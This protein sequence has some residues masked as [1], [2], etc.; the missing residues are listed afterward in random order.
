MK[1][2]NIIRDVD[3]NE[4]QKKQIRQTHATN[5]NYIRAIAPKEYRQRPS[6]LSDIKDN[7]MLSWI[8]QIA[9]RYKYDNGWDH[10]PIDPTYNPFDNNFDEFIP[11]ADKF[12]EVYNKEHDMALRAQI[13]RNETRR[14]RLADGDRI[15][16]A[17]AAGLLDPLVW[18]PI[19]LA[20]GVG[21]VKGATRAGLATGALVGAT[22]PIRLSLDPTA[23]IDE[24]ATVVGMGLI[25]G[26]LIGGM[27]GKLSGPVARKALNN[28]T[29]KQN[30]DAYNR[31]FHK[32]KG[33]VDFESIN[34]SL[35][36]IDYRKNAP[37]IVIR[38]INTVNPKVKNSQIIQQQTIEQTD[39]PDGYQA[40]TRRKL[41]KYNPKTDELEVD[42][43]RAKK[44]YMD[45]R[46]LQPPIRGAKP[47]NPNLIPN[48]DEYV[49]FIIRKEIMK[50]KVLPKKRKDESIATYENRINEEVIKD[51]AQESDVSFE[52]KTNRFF[53]AVEGITNVG[54]L[55]IFTRRNIGSI[56]KEIT[57]IVQRAALA[58][59]DFGTVTKAVDQGIA[60]NP[61]II[62]KLS[63]THNAKLIATL[64][65][66]DADFNKIVGIDENS[67]II[68]QK[69]ARG[70]LALDSLVSKATQQLEDAST[71]GQDSIKISKKQYTEDLG[72]YLINP[73]LVDNI[74]ITSVRNT[75]KNSLKTLRNYFKYYNKEIERLDMYQGQGSLNNFSLAKAGNAELARKLLEQHKKKPF[76]RLESKKRLQQI[77]QKLEN[78]AKRRQNIEDLPKKS[79][80]D[81]NYLPRIWRRDAILENVDAFKGVLRKYIQ[82]QPRSNA[83]TTRELNNRVDEIYNN[84]MDIE[85]DAQDI[86]GV[87]GY[88]KDADGR[89]KVGTRN[90]LQ[91]EFDI[92]NEL[93]EDFIETDVDFILRG[94]SRR[95]GAAV[96]ITR[97]FGDTHMVN[98]LD[99]LEIKL[100]EKNIDSTKR[101]QI[102]NNLRDEKDKI[103]GILN[104]QNPAGFS[105]RTTKLLRNWASLAYMGRVIFSAL[106]DLARPILVNGFS[107]TYKY[108]IRPWLQSLDLYRRQV[109]ELD[110]LS[111]IVE[112]TLDTAPR[113]IFGDVG[114]SLG[115][116]LGGK[117]DKYVN[118]P[119]ERAQAPF[120]VIN[121]L[122]PWTHHMK[123]MQGLVAMH[124]FLEDSIKW[125]KGQLDNFGQERLL[126]YGIDKRTADVI[127]N[128]PIQK[129]DSALVANAMEWDGLR[130]GA[131][132]RRKLGYAIWSDTQRTIVT[133]TS[134][135]Q[136]NMMTGVIRLNNEELAQWFDNPVFRTMG[137]QKTELGGKFSNA[138]LGLPFQFFSW[139]IAANRK[140]LISLAQN[141]EVNRVGGITALISMGMLG[142]YFKNPR[143]YAQKE[144]EEK[145]LRG[146][147]L[148]GVLALFGDMN[149]MMETISEGTTGHMVGARAALG[150]EGRFGRANEMD[151]VGEVIGA[152]PG[153]FA[154]LIYAFGSGNLTYNERVD[155]IQRMVPLN[156]LWLWDQTYR[157]IVRETIKE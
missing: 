120:Y 156:S 139:G 99:N 150:L 137:F 138:W 77:A 70:S 7:F 78:E 101:N 21:F 107:N 4:E 97:E 134:T 143:Y 82:S 149:F 57:S 147:E 30:I 124:R 79:I 51:I 88:A 23:T 153:L 157:D 65:S 62:M 105:Q 146:V 85:V 3:L 28:K 112:M 135:D 72:R 25:T 49:K 22:E 140:V 71:I 145:I 125:N 76:L 84:I 87:A 69:I 37:A 60:S 33:L 94:Y 38:E 46:W 42:I 81:P 17:F 154:D 40:K 148:S 32:Q 152:G 136:Y 29:P 10:A 108:A 18:V 74:Q 31:A 126:S 90:L 96:E 95:M 80:D 50:A 127:A 24:S 73:D 53:Q 15:T 75:V 103:L 83:L 132:A 34:W 45:G 47:L 14:Q 61:S 5:T 91:R 58:F 1:T 128:M 121:G 89:Y 35:K 123:R 115:G 104:T 118:Q 6:Y 54:S 55:L 142:D 63:T 13:K 86:E 20:T 39:V 68:R 133:P 26:G 116:R 102:I 9:D 67:G 66:I 131:D 16:P 59:D 27:V 48:S 64:K 113:R 2:S 117:F 130:G 151:A 144:T 52:T 110:Y 19:P 36:N 129:R 56:N 100:L 122:A 111:P 43:V 93:V 44:Q 92:P 119:F 114:E 8:G 41:A 12:T 141:R 98:F 106:P 109:R 155:M 11:Y